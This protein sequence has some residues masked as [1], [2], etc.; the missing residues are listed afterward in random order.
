LEIPAANL[1]ENVNS[2]LQ[3]PNFKWF[4]KLTSLSQV[5]GQIPMT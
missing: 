2:K 1:V 3:N 4:D 5:E